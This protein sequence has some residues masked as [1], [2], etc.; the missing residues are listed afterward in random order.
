MKEKLNR[1]FSNMAMPDDCADRIQRAM[2]RKLRQKTQGRY[3][4]TVNPGGKSHWGLAACLALLLVVGGGAWMLWGGLGGS[5]TVTL[6]VAQGWQTTETYN[7]SGYSLDY[8]QGWTVVDPGKA[9]IFQ[10]PKLGRQALLVIEQQKSENLEQRQDQE[11]FVLPSSEGF[12][13]LQIQS[14]Q[15]VTLDGFTGGK[16]SFT[17]GP[18]HNQ[19][20]QYTVVEAGYIF[21]CNIPETDS[22][23]YRQTLEG[24]VEGIRL[25]AK[26]APNPIPE[27]MSQYWDSSIWMLWPMEGWHLQENQGQDGRTLS[28]LDDKSNGSLTISQGEAWI[29]NSI[30]GT[31]GLRTFGPDEPANVQKSVKTLDGNHAAYSSFTQEGTRCEEYC[32]VVQGVGF[33]INCSYPEEQQDTLGPLMEEMVQSIVFFPG[34]PPERDNV[35]MQLENPICS[36]EKDGIKLRYRQDWTIEPSESSVSEVTFTAPTG[37]AKFTLRIGP[38][39]AVLESQ[40]SRLDDRGLLEISP[41]EGAL[42]INPMKEILAGKVF[43]SVSYI[44]GEPE[45]LEMRYIG[46]V[47]NRAVGLAVTCENE[48]QSTYLPML[49]E[50]IGSLSFTDE[51]CWA[52]QAMMYILEDSYLHLPDWTASEE[53]DQEFWSQFLFM[54]FTSA[55]YYQ[56]DDGTEIA[57]TEVGDAEVVTRDWGDYKERL[58]KISQEQAREYGKLV[59]GKTL[60]ELNIH[61]FHDTSNRV[62]PFYEDGFYYIAVSDFGATWYR[63][64]SVEYEAGGNAVVLFDILEEGES[65][66]MGEARAVVAPADNS[67]GF[68]VVEKTTDWNPNGVQVTVYVPD[69]WVMNLVPKKVWVNSAAE[70]ELFQ[71]IIQELKMEGILGEVALKNMTIQGETLILD[72]DQAFSDQVNATGLTGENIIIG[73]VVNSFLDAYP[74]CRTVTITVEGRSW[75]SGHVVYD[76]PLT[77]RDPAL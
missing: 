57:K 74:Q 69:N 72:F 46:E 19:V 33:I 49:N 24:M 40:G 8:P 62:S 28:F 44:H 47:G 9:V 13:N 48:E 68:T 27:G 64:K 18:K 25:D 17:Y 76:G 75:E 16:V 38:M 43:A 11:G 58:I 70:Q 56:S 10:D 37:K 61:G 12:E 22:E 29:V 65:S 34:E 45:L 4:S 67:R 2:R 71:A 23:E 41:D 14:K 50:M 59:T 66:S 31:D 36:I 3:V 1:A 20:V 63:V 77:R 32:A 7:G 35:V 26:P 60:P 73:S 55:G 54:S 6:P 5:P 15:V 30:V 51:N 53:L 21:T 42:L 52:T 39:D